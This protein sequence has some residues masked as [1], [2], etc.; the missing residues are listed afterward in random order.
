[1]QSKGNSVRHILAPSNSS[2]MSFPTLADDLSDDVTE[3]GFDGE[4]QSTL[5]PI[6][7]AKAYTVNSYFTQEKSPSACG[8]TRATPKLRTQQR[9]VCII[10]ALSY[11]SCS[12]SDAGLLQ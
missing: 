2:E 3:P 4:L 9:C 1:M 5:C 10:K 8:S 11:C 6:N 7:T 12:T